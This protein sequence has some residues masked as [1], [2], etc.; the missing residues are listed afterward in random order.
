M[1]KMIHV[2]VAAKTSS[3]VRLDAVVVV[4]DVIHLQPEAFLTSG[5]CFKNE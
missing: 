4:R 3:V 1:K 5:F 2:E